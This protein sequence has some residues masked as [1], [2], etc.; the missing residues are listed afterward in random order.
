LYSWNRKD[1]RIVGEVKHFL[2]LNLFLP[3]WGLILLQKAL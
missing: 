1:K 2:W 3:V